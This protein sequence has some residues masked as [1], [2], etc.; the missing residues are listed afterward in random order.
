MTTTTAA[1]TLTD[2]VD[3][4]GGRL[5][6]LAMS[7]D[8]NAKLTVLLFAPGER[9]PSLV[10]KVPTTDAAVSQVQSEAR[11]LAQLADVD[12]G[13]LRRTVPAVV[14]ICEHQGRPVLVT[15]GLA[16][17]QL[18]AAYHAWRHTARPGEVRVDFAAAASWL[19]ALQAVSAN[20]TV[21]LSATLA[22]VSDVLWDR[23][24][25]DPAVAGDVR[26][27]KQLAE[28]LSGYQVPR[29]VA[30][31]DLWFGNL[32]VDDGQVSGVV[33]WESGQ[34]AGVPTRDL[35]RFALTYSLYL[36]RH[37]RPGRV[38]AGH[39]GLRAGV[40]GAGVDYAVTGVGWYPDLV[41]AFTCQGL[42]RLGVPGHLW[43][44]VLLAEIACIAAEADHPE[45]AVAH[46][47]V[48]RRLRGVS[49]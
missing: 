26:R 23:F 10:A 22:G 35:A 20:G 32:L 29:T 44:A 39:R 37:T 6:C 40:W 15:A 12:L 7:K 49:R 21:D 46:L 41:R 9:E 17:R 27:V 25:A 30:H 24:G 1:R 45:F 18:L 19:G 38:V 42:A 16:G 36:D 33:D 47:Q 43:R 5:V 3:Q 11:L 34:L 8:P 28:Q 48:L 13:S 2:L 4:V 14:E 31:G